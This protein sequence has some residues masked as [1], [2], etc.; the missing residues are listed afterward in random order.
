M[1][2]NELLTAVGVTM[3]GAASFMLA[4]SVLLQVVKGR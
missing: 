3:G 1:T 4:M 2:I